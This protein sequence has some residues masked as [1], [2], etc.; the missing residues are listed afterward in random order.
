MAC[1]NGDDYDWDHSVFVDPKLAAVD[2][3]VNAVLTYS[4]IAVELYMDRHPF[5]PS[6]A[7]NYKVTA[8]SS[9][10]NYSG[11]KVSKLCYNPCSY[12]CRSLQN[13]T[14]KYAFSRRPRINDFLLLG[15]LAQIH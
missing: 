15:Y 12:C 4:G 7:G 6:N 1:D 5:Q 14:K 2:S 9:D 11:S 13:K 10:L 8:S 3:T